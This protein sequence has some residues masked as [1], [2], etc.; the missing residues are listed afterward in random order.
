MWMEEESM[1][2]KRLDGPMAFW[3]D[4]TLYS[5]PRQ[6]PHSFESGAIESLAIIKVSLYLVQYPPL[7]NSVCPLNHQPSVT[8]NLTIGAMSSILVRLPRIA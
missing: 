3:F 8:R 1:L 2:N 6:W 4:Q 7:A 5:Y